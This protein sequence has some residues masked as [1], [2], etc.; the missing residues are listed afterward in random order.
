MTKISREELAANARA[1]DIEINHVGQFDSIESYKK[2]KESTGK[3]EQISEE[4][5]QLVNDEGG[6]PN[7]NFEYTPEQFG[8]VGDGATDDSIP[9]GISHSNLEFV[10]RFSRIDS[11]HYRFQVTVIFMAVVKF[12]WMMIHLRSIFLTR[13]INL[14]LLW[15]T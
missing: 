8:A 7:K 3:N 10:Y 4:I 15:R 1:A 5:I 14:I 13:L 12:T 2:D 9:I 6:L 11:N